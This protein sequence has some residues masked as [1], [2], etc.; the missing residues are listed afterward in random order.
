MLKQLEITLNNLVLGEI[1]EIA[2]T[3]SETLFAGQPVDL[4]LNS[5]AAD[6]ARLQQITRHLSKIP[7]M[8]QSHGLDRSKPTAPFADPSRDSA[9]RR[10][11]RGEDWDVVVVDPPRR[12]DHH[13]PF[14]C[15]S[16]G[17]A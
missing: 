14:C 12:S 17:R 16:L 4:D 10:Q 15:R 9:H 11:I 7:A 6:P 8:G 2:L 1:S 5:I 13:N 3:N